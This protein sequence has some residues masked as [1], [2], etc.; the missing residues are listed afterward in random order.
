M[1]T[2][3][4]AAL[5]MH[6][7]TNIKA[8]LNIC[9]MLFVEGFFCQSII[10]DHVFDTCKRNLSISS[11]NEPLLCLISALHWPIPQVLGLKTPC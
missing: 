11:G 3:S 5:T 6:L 1:R 2:F 10:R 8:D 7:L 4:T 9:C